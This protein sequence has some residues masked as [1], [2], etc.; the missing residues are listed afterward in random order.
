L[1]REQKIKN[2]KQKI[3]NKKSGIRNTRGYGESGIEKTIKIG[4]NM[5][6]PDTKIL[7]DLE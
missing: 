3:K 6:G 5:E 4:E 1:R 2:K 7:V